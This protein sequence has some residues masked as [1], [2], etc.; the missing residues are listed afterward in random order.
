MRDRAL[1]GGVIMSPLPEDERRRAADPGGRLK[2]GRVVVA[3]LHVVVEDT[4][5]APFE[6]AHAA[7]GDPLSRNIRSAYLGRAAVS[8][9]GHHVVGRMAVGPGVLPRGRPRRASAHWSPAARSPCTGK[10]SATRPRGR[11]GSPWNDRQGRLTPH[12][13]HR[14]HP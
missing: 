6:Q 13:R 1:R 12:L 7:S 11:E 2:A 9:D 8:P 14:G 4:V 5:A 10:G 3:G